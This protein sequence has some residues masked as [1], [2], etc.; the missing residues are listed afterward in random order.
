[1]HGSVP[2]D[3]LDYRNVPFLSGGGG[4]GSYVTF[5]AKTPICCR[6]LEQAV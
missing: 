3:C 2:S 1:M 5:V 4:E 6:S